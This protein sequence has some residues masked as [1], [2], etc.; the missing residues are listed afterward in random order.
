VPTVDG[1]ETF[2]GTVS[3]QLTSFSANIT[4]RFVDHG[5]AEIRHAAATLT[6][7]LAGVP[8]GSCSVTGLTLTIS[9]GMLTTTTPSGT[10][11]GVSFQG[12][13]VG[14]SNVTFDANC[15]PVI[16]TMTFTGPAA[17]LTPAGDSVPVTF[18]ALVM[19]VDDHADPARFD[20]TGGMSATCFGGTAGV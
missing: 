6:G 3:V 10:A 14:F 5:G 12:T 18:D 1:V 15:V 4:M 8:G 16:Y 20:L 2:N 13:V 9:S 11:V 17:L 19:N 7:S